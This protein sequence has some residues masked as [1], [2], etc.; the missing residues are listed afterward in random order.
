MIL[1]IRRGAGGERLSITSRYSKETKVV[2]GQ[3]PS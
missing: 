1:E 2:I 3:V